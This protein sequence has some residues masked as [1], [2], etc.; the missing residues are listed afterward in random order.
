MVIGIQ[1]VFCEHFDTC[2]THLTHQEI[3]SLQRPP[4]LGQEPTLS[5]SPLLT[6]PP[7]PPPHQQQGS[8]QQPY[9]LQSRGHVGLEGHFVQSQQPSMQSMGHDRSDKLQYGGVQILPAKQPRQH[10]NAA[11]DTVGS[12]G[13]DHNLHSFSP[14]AGTQAANRGFGSQHAQQ[15]AAYDAFEP[16]HAQ[17]QAAYDAFEPQHAQQQVG[18]RFAH[19]SAG[20]TAQHTQ[21]TG[22]TE[23]LGQL[24]IHGP[25]DDRQ[26]PPYSLSQSNLTFEAPAIQHPDELAQGG[27][28]RQPRQSSS[29]V[30]YTDRPK[31]GLSS[32]PRQRPYEPHKQPQSPIYSGNFG[33]SQAVDGWDAPSS[34]YDIGTSKYTA[35]QSIRQTGDQPKDPGQRIATSG[36][37]Q[38]SSSG[39]GLSGNDA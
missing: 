27:Q 17:Q 3:A 25:G 12:G 15:Q 30:I 5:N 16:Q 39:T 28:Y 10:L 36:F 2:I 22:I 29:G 18:A 9:S 6:Q 8:A 20:M 1:S 23:T 32:Q 38:R 21:Q 35:E 13:W 34:S 24:Q 14:A 26:G 31:F 37:L 11:L 33:Q 4:G 19:S 7:P